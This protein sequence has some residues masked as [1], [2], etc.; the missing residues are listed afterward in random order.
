MFLVEDNQRKNTRHGGQADTAGKRIFVKNG[1]SQATFEPV[2]AAQEV[3][4]D[5]L[6]GFLGLF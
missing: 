3:I 6:L 1:A 4:L 2:L 5:G